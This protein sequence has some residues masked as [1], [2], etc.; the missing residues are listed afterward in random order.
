MHVYYLDIIV[1]FSRH[2]HQFFT[3][4]KR[5]QNVQHVELIKHETRSDLLFPSLQ[6]FKIFLY[7]DNVFLNHIAVYKNLNGFSQEN[8]HMKLLH[9][10]CMYKKTL[11]TPFLQ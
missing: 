4:L 5:S 1:I 8:L 10:E 11:G 7:S 6:N 3:L 9:T 2:F